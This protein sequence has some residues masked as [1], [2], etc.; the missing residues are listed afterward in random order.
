MECKSQERGMTV[1]VKLNVTGMTCAA[2]S[3]RVEKVTSQIQGVH[4]VE[5]NLLA[6]T[7]GMD[8]DDSTLV[9]QAI[10]RIIKAG[11]GASVP[12]E[13]SEKKVT[14]PNDLRQMKS[15]LI[16]S[17][18]FLIVLMYFTMGHM[19]GLPLPAWYMGTKNALV[20]VL[21]QFLL[22]M[23]VVLL[24]HSKLPMVKSI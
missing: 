17:A 21:T 22:T 23:P 14:M 1:R 24:N 7:L 8:V 9:Q 19:I 3:A 20:A 10:E 16:F 5:V 4:N 13:K 2:C 11:Y 12:G 18:T 6:G 15:R